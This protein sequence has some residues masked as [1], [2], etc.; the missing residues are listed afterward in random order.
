MKGNNLFYYLI[1]LCICWTACV[2]VN[3]T[4]NTVDLSKNIYREDHHA[5]EI[6]VKMQEKLG[7][8]DYFTRVTNIIKI[9]T[10]LVVGELGKTIFS[11]DR[12]YVLDGKTNVLFCLDTT[13]R[14]I[15]KYDK[16]GGGPMEYKKMGD[17]HIRDG[18]I[19]ILDPYG[20]KIIRLNK[21]GTFA[22]YTSTKQIK[23][24]I[25]P[26]LIFQDEQGKYVLFT[27]DMG[28]AMEFPYEFA[29]MDSSLKILGSAHIGKSKEPR[30]KR[31]SSES[32]PVRPFSDNTGFFYTRPLDDTIYAFEKDVFKSKYVIDFGHRK[33][34]SAMRK[35]SSLT[36]DNFLETGYASNLQFVFETDSVLTFSYYLT[37]HLQTVFYNKY[38]KQQDEFSMILLNMG[39]SLQQIR[40]IG[41]WKNKFLMQVEPQ[42]LLAAVVQYK[43][44]HP[45]K[46]QAEINAE[47]KQKYPLLSEMLQN[48]TVNSNP[49]LLCV[50]PINSK[51]FK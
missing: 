3:A 41:T 30:I 15:W 31:W 43:K 35:L 20:R 8:L 34:P 9:D 19:L 47:I 1:G 18:Q 14:L 5:V 51:L 16:I 11:D 38:T 33:V 10:T 21:N 22:G 39:I 7:L 13:G 25:Y 50:E 23:G 27:R 24:G 48:T 42:V 46:N 12:L 29:I 37:H 26:E 49:I 4:D 6:K 40:I 44:D 36:L 2:N 28:N 17:F 45:G 32:F